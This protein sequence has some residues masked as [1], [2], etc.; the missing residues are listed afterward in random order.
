VSFNKIA[1]TYSKAERARWTTISVVLP[2]LQECFVH[3]LMNRIKKLAI[4][5]TSAT[6][7]QKNK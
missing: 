2:V 1:T 6:E 4:F 5:A 7:Q 3:A